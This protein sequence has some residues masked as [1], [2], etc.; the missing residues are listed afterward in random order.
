MWKFEYFLSNGQCPCENL[1]ISCPCEYCLAGGWRK[2]VFPVTSLSQGGGGGQLWRIVEERKQIQMQR[3]GLFRVGTIFLQFQF[4][5]PTELAS[6]ENGDYFFLSPWKVWFKLRI[7]A[8]DEIWCS[9]QMMMPLPL[10]WQH[11]ICQLLLE[12]LNQMRL[13]AC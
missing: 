6:V 10:V 4:K 8:S 1:N 9:D 12:S 13:V 2:F 7:P 3:K 11:V 5:P